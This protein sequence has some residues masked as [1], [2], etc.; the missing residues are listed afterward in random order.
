MQ[1]RRFSQYDAIF[2][3]CMG[4][5][6]V[7][8]QTFVFWSSVVASPFCLAATTD[9]TQ[10]VEPQVVDWQLFRRAAAPNRRCFE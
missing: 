3:G 10:E 1:L 9:G 4:N 6:S 8:N 2:V 5:P 7:Y